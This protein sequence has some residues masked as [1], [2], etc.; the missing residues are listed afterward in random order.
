MLVGAAFLRR[1]G[2]LADPMIDLRLF[3]APAFSIAVTANAL[4]L[5]T[6]YGMDLFIAQYLQLVLGM[7]PFEAGLWLLPSAVG[8]IV[9]SNLAPLMAGRVS[10][11]H[12]VAGGAALTALGLAMLT[13][14]GAESGLAV[15]V[16]GSV[17]MAVGAAQVIT[18]GTDLVV[19]AAPAERA[20]SRH[21]RSQR[22]GSSSAARS[23][24]RCWAASAPP[25]I[26]ARP[27]A[28]RS[29]TRSARSTPPPRR[30]PTACSWPRSR[31]RSWMVAIAAIAW[32]LLRER[33]DS[34]A[35][36]VAAVAPVPG[37]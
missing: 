20:G 34:A 36:P 31:A 29:R 21:R 37:A 30:S 2:K 1:Q 24:S 19:G 27:A 5:F 14:V 4:A 18:L 22:P 10:N 35:R 23:G 12:V 3:R 8:F 32:R 7:S 26:A 11:G 17:V 16:A 33:S 9:G 6:V 15:L 25:S 13:Q 28:R